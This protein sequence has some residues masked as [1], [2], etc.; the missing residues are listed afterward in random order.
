MTYAMQ[1][2]N[3]QCKATTHM[4]MTAYTSAITVGALCDFSICGWCSSRCEAYDFANNV[5]QNI[6]VCSVC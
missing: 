2:V 3:R 5:L 4:S 6:D 1:L